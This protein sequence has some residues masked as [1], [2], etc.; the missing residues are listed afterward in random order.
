MRLDVR[1]ARLSGPAGSVLVAADPDG[2]LLQVRAGRHTDADLQA[3]ALAADLPVRRTTQLHVDGAV[4]GIGTGSCGP[5]TLP[6][7]RVGPGRYRWRWWLVVQ[8][9]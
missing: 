5:D 8:A 1:W 7:Y 2:P 4:R 6:A 9:R 3:A